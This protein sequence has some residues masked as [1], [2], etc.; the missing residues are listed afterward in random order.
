MKYCT[1]LLFWAFSIYLNAQQTVFYNWLRYNQQKILPAYYSV[2]YW[3]SYGLVETDSSYILPY[4]TSDYSQGE[5]GFFILRRNGVLDSVLLWDIYNPKIIE[6]N[7]MDITKLNPNLYCFQRRLVDSFKKN[8]NDFVFVDSNFN[9]IRQ[10]SYTKSSSGLMLSIGIYN[11]FNQKSVLSKH[12]YYLKDS[13]TG[14]QTSRT[15]AELVRVD[16]NGTISV[17]YSQLGRED[18]WIFEFALDTLDSTYMIYSH[19]DIATDYEFDNKD[20]FIFTKMKRTGEIVWQHKWHQFK[21]KYVVW[22][23]KPNLVI[24]ESG[25]KFVADF[26]D[27]VDDSLCNI[28]FHVARDGK[29]HKEIRRYTNYEMYD[30]R[31]HILSSS[32][33]QFYLFGYSQGDTSEIVFDT[34]WNRKV[35][36]FCLHITKTDSNGNK[37][38]SRR[39]NMN[40]TD[41][42]FMRDWRVMT[43]VRRV[44]DGGFLLYGYALGVFYSLP[45]NQQNNHVIVMKTDSCGFGPRD[46]CKI[47][48]KIDSIRYNTVYISLDENKVCGRRWHVQGQ[49][50][51]SE[52]L[53]YSFSDTGTYT[54]AIWGFAGAT[55][56]STNI[57]VRISSL[58]SCRSPKNQVCTMRA[59]LDSQKCQYIRL[60]IDGSMSQYCTRH[61]EIEDKK[62][63]QDTVSYTFS[64]KSKYTAYLIGRKAISIDTSKIEVVVDCLSQIMDDHRVSRFQIYPNPS[65]SF[66]II[67]KSMTDRREYTLDLYNLHGTKIFSQNLK[68]PREQINTSS[69]PSGLYMIIISDSETTELLNQKIT[70][71]H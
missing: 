53:I 59:I 60:H 9:Q 10:T 44:S 61:W 34:Q 5:G 63:Y 12:Q 37:I 11:D 58:D 1:L 71:Q 50:R 29:S 19:T 26:I 16:T 27:F 22:C 51:T 49:T 45:P 35:N 23:H 15:V 56:D 20:T 70:I 2:D 47:I 13:I 54:I 24:D 69:I 32:N 21:T 43:H 48:P 28:L 38:W 33:N 64:Q 39:H 52:K 3:S 42:L 57:A 17:L 46:T 14:Q 7:I 65:H 6:N 8:Y 25:Y 31:S 68:A 18:N 30:K 66:I 36:N 4:N 67:E 62:F 55:T 40:N 41:V